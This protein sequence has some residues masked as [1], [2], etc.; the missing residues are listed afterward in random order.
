MELNKLKKLFSDIEVQKEQN[1]KL[2]KEN[3]QLK[4]K[5][6][7]LSDMIALINIGNIDLG[8]KNYIIQEIEKIRK[9]LN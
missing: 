5:L 8:L 2:K 7:T 1:K 9:G 3:K 4:N 6:K